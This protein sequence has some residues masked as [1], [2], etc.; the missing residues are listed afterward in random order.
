MVWNM[1]LAMDFPSNLI[2]G[3]QCNAMGSAGMSQNKTKIFYHFY[4]S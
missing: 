3:M 1:P 4:D 2:N